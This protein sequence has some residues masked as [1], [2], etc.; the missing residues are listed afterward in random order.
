MIL[1]VFLQIAL[2]AIALWDLIKRDEV[3]HLPRFVWG[4][5]I[6]ILNFIGPISYLL[7]GR[8]RREG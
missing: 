2:M 4:V 8:A 5:V 6:V 7:L 3:A 1:L